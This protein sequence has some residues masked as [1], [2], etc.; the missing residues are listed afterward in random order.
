MLLF[1]NRFLRFAFIAALLASVL[2]VSYILF[3]IYVL[4]GII[5]SYMERKAAE[6]VG[7]EANVNVVETQLFALA[8]T[9]RDFSVANKTFKLTWDS[10][11]FDA[12]LRSIS[13][14]SI[15]LNELRIHGL[16]STLKIDEKSSVSQL[17]FATQAFLARAN[18][19]LYIERFTIQ[20][21]SFEIIDNR[22]EKENRFVIKPISFSLEKFSTQYSPEQGN[23]YNL[24]FTGLNGGFFRWNGNLQWMPF[25]SEGEMEI[26]GLDVLQLRDF[27]QKHLPFVLQNAALDLHTSYRI[28]EEPEFGFELKNAKLA[29]N[30]PALFADSS[31]LTMKASSIQLGTL[32]LSSLNRTVFANSIVLDSVNANY[33]LL[34]AIK[35]PAPDLFEFIRYNENAPD[36]ADANIFSTF[37][38]KITNL[39]RWQIQ[40]D[41]IK[42]KQARVGFIDSITVPAVAYNL[43]V[44]Q[45]LLTDVAN[46]G[47]N[48]V[49]IHFLS[50][51]NNSKLNF[52]GAAHLFPLQANGTFDIKDFLLTDLQ[53]YL[54]QT[55]WLS[56]R[57][58]RLAGVVDMRWRPSADS[59]QDTLVFAG[60]AGIDSLRMLGKD[61]NDL[62]GMQ[63]I[64]VKDLDIMFAPRPHFQIGRVNAQAPVAYLARRANSGA[65]F[66]QIMKQ[67]PKSA[68][69]QGTTMPLNIN[70][71]NINRGVIYFADKSPT[72]PFSYRMTTVNGNLRNISNQKNNAS[73]S[74]QGKM[75]GYAPFSMKGVFNVSGRYPY[76]NFTAETA[77]QDLVIFS[78][79]SGRHAGYKIS[80]GQVALQVDY[81][82]QRNKVNGKNHIVIQHLTFGEKVESPDATNMPV[83]LGVA[84]LSDKNGVIDLDIAI[85]GDLDDPEFSVGSLIW[86]IIKNLLGKA[87]SAPFKS[88]MSLVSSNSDPE[89]ITF[90][91]GSEY[92]DKTQIEALK[93][94]SNALMQRPQLQL[95]VRGNADPDK[96]GNALKE[97][98][99]LKAL[100]RNMP[101]GSKWT[102]ASVKKAPQRDTLFAYYKRTEK[103]D[104]HSVL[105]NAV[106][107]DAGVPE[108]LQVQAA[109]QVWNE[110]L[111]NQKLPQNTLQY[112]AN[113]RAQNI[114]LELINVNATLGERIFV[115][116]DSHLPSSVANLKIRE[117]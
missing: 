75:G 15:S 51:L 59:L 64:D 68:N 88:L 93:S 11:H 104:W 111:A 62:I 94:L 108:E 48:S 52:Q 65:N 60:N 90:A 40:I 24:Q 112:L 73:L 110:L 71:V 76:V 41:S 67:K 66:S 30:K 81:K 95:D 19:P 107:V 116:D 63:R 33:S 102:A 86:K 50:S 37:F 38:R 23:N 105:P 10:L 36:S 100:T 103:K 44:E 82:I 61:N 77:N 113:A 53:N 80:K 32:Q 3:T 42:T 97:A 35:Q 56:L 31:K 101:A 25:L 22:D 55:S 92:L 109:G 79:Y 5:K 43:N 117:Y 99:L 58:G 46:R 84:L 78:P 72:T 29:L 21:G 17:E 34:S 69:A 2:L 85:E 26:R 8:F 27:Y 28:T 16:Q 91:P 96:D 106:S 74:I 9:A 57:R 114:K 14:R 45:L 6:L 20:N 87:I 4:P 39:P 18:E 98:Q 1:R 115:V 12:Q 7:G 49:N 83:R 47:D 54:S 13:K 70:Q 89:S